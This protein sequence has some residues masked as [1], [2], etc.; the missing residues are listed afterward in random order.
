MKKRGGITFHYRGLY[1]LDSLYLAAAKGGRRSNLASKGT[2]RSE[3]MRLGMPW[4]Y[5][6]FDA[7]FGLYALTTAEWNEELV[8]AL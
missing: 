4:A 1:A 2:V 3:A 5:W 8:A 7:T 6:E